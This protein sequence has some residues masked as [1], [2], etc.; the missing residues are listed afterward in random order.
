VGWVSE[1]SSAGAPSF[2][3]PCVCLGIVVVESAC[4]SDC[5]DLR[6]CKVGI[7]GWSVGDECVG[8]GVV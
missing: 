8:E 3:G 6:L 7:V 5:R 2:C 4:V 1:G